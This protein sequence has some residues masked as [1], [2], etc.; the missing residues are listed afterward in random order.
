MNCL[1]NRLVVPP[2]IVEEKEVTKVL[3]STKLNQLAEHARKSIIAISENP[4]HGKP[5]K[6]KMVGYRECYIHGDHRVVFKYDPEKHVIF[7]VDICHKDSQ[8]RNFR[9][10]YD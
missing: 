10:G 3:D 9:N 7:V 2:M 4:E 8:T 6:N 5:L 1:H